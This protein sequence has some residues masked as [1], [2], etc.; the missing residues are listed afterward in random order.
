MAKV[1]LRAPLPRDPC[2]CQGQRGAGRR[3]HAVDSGVHGALRAP[4]QAGRADEH[5]AEM[6]G[7]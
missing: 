5:A 2:G 3:P 4:L 1:G 6:A 7:L